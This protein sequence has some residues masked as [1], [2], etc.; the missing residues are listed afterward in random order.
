MADFGLTESMYGSNYF[1][2]RK[3]AAESEKIPIWWMAP[4]SIENDVYN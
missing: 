3:S 1:R 2:Q 4:E